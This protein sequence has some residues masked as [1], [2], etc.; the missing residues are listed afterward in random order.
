[1]DTTVKKPASG[2]HLV[3]DDE[4]DYNGAPDPQKWTYDLGNHQWAN[5]ELQAYTNQAENVFVKDGTLTIQAIKKQDGDKQYT[6]ARL[7]T[8][9]LHS[10]QYGLF[11]FRVKLPKGKGSWPAV[12]MISDAGRQGTAWPRCG[13]IDIVEYVGKKEREL[14]FSL[15]SEGHNHQRH[16]R[17]QY[18]SFVDYEGLSDSFHDYTMEWTPDFIEFLVDG[19]SLCRYNKS[20][21]SEDQSE[22]SWPFDQPFFLIL[23]IA[24]GGNLG[25]PVD[26]SAMPFIMEVEHVRVYQK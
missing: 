5:N 12:W 13:E 26:E 2:Y 7:N 4:F 1:M 10:W 19:N 25:G 6:S 23:N 18:T 9:G 16:D 14:L 24:V 17:K 3:W 8:Y 11:E 22:I 15:H 20:D 21:D